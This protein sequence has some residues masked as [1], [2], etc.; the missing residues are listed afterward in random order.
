MILIY[1]KIQAGQPLLPWL[2]PTVL[3][4]SSRLSILYLA[5]GAQIGAEQARNQA[6]QGAVVV[7]SRLT[8]LLANATRQ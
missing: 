5:L 2:E 6:G 3:A 1:L 4:G 8:G 7:K